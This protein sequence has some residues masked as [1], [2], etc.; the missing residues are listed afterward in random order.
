MHDWH[1]D[2]CYRCCYTQTFRVVTTLGGRAPE[3]KG[4]VDPEQ[5]PVEQRM[6][7]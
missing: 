6:G 2:Y 1:G 5:N 4:H 7:S 3:N